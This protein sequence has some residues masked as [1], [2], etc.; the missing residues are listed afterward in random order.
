V[1]TV[2]T[3][4]KIRTA[5]IRQ[6]HSFWLT[7]WNFIIDFEYVFDYQ[8]VHK[9]MISLNQKDR[10]PFWGKF[11]EALWT[12]VSVPKEKGRFDFKGEWDIPAM[13]TKD[14][15]KNMAIEIPPNLRRKLV[16]EQSLRSA[17][18][19]YVRIQYDTDDLCLLGNVSRFFSDQTDTLFD[20]TNNG[21]MAIYPLSLISQF[22]SDVDLEK[23]N[24][25]ICDSNAENIFLTHG[26][27]GPIMISIR[28]KL[29]TWRMKQVNA[30]D[31]IRGIDTY[32]FI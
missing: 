30:G 10:H 31:N 18:N 32:V 14:C 21:N 27:R 2:I 19:D 16:S 11:K 3:M 23:P 8:E 15:L 9:A 6:I 17:G 1:V 22:M 4:D 25:A 12:L 5:D 24:S 28:K 20:Y 7:I 13:S 26:L 29:N